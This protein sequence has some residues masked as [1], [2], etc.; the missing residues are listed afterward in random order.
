MH[1]NQ[2]V[3][4][5][6][7]TVWPGVISSEAFLCLQGLF[8]GASLRHYYPYF[9]FGLIMFQIC[10]YIASLF[11]KN[12]EIN[13]LRTNSLQSQVF[14]VF[15]VQMVMMLQLN[16][17]ICKFSVSTNFARA[18]WQKLQTALAEERDVCFLLQS[19]V[20]PLW[21][22]LL[23]SACKSENWYAVDWRW[24]WSVTQETGIR[25]PEVIILSSFCWCGARGCWAWELVALEQ[26]W[27]IK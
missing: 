27:S 2:S 15:S 25:L 1:T 7:K 24:K 8:G 5:E 10:T 14:L 17:P 12:Q 11:R 16:Q 21:C 18:L 26:Q 19:L 9:E 13:H 20:C 3:S 6:N 4:V 23:K 22:P